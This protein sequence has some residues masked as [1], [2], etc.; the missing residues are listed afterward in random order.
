MKLALFDLDHTL[1][2]VDSADNW[3]RFVVDKGS[4]DAVA[5]SARIRSFA[6]AYHAGRFDVEAYLDFQMGMLTRFPR[7]RLEL[8]RAQYLRE[9]ILPHV[10][11]EALELVDAWRRDGYK[12]VLITG[13]TAFISR[14][15]TAAFGMDH[16]L[17]VEPEQIDG[18]YTGRY[19][20]THTHMEGKVRAVDAFMRSRGMTLEEC[21]DSVFYSDSINDLPLLS[22]VKH[23]VATNA[24]KR[25]RAV[26]AERGWPILDL[27]E[28]IH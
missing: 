16:L 23:P 14:P 13:T 7:P 20:G 19:V 25:L 12:T 11:L 21:A 6:D 17:A 15:I 24:D 4:L 18:R 27:F 1:L 28:T 3:L 2:P 5:Y 26:A 10:R 22:R 8:W 9:F